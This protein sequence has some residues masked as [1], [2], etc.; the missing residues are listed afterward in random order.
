[1]NE[2]EKLFLEAARFRMIWFPPSEFCQSAS[3]GY[4]ITVR[5]KEYMDFFYCNDD[6]IED[7]AFMEE[8]RRKLELSALDT[9]MML[10]NGAVYA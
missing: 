4:K 7:R 3:I 1:M 5:G 9:I 6:A 10:I 2:I 8:A